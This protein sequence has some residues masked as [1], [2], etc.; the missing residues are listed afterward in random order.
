MRN[1]KTYHSIKNSHQ[2]EAYH[3]PHMV[4]EPIGFPPTATSLTYI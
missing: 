2:D 4:S 3:K 1:G